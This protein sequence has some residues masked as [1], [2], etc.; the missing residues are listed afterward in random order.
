VPIVLTFVLDLLVCTLTAQDDTSHTAMI[1][2][3]E[4]SG[5]YLAPF[6]TLTIR[7]IALSRFCVSTALYLQHNHVTIWLIASRLCIRKRELASLMWLDFCIPK[8][9]ST[10]AEC[11]CHEL[12]RQPCTEQKPEHPVRNALASLAYQR[13]ECTIAPA[14][15]VMLYG[16][17][18]VICHTNLMI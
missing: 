3:Y 13:K 9:Y 4:I 11:W 7:F 1:C 10:T 5:A 15:S 14:V 18:D 16:L 6:S 2:C 8:M 17:Q 12:L